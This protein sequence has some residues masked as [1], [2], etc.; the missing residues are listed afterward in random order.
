MQGIW[1][2]EGHW[3]K[4]GQYLGEFPGGQGRPDRRE[5]KFLHLQGS[6]G[7]RYWEHSGNG[8]SEE[9][10]PGTVGVQCVHKWSR[11]GT[12]VMFLSGPAVP[13]TLSLWWSFGASFGGDTLQTH[14]FS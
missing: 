8:I 7:E 10:G 3:G 4:K 14:V 9:Q 13:F 2:E 5:I 11:G 12:R 1:G 6:C